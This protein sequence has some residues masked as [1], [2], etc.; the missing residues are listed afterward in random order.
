MAVEG[1]LSIFTVM[2]NEPNLRESPG[3]MT[4]WSIRFPFR[5]VPLV[6]WRSTIAISPLWW[7]IRQCFFEME[8]IGI[9][10]SQFGARPIKVGPGGKWKVFCQPSSLKRIRF[11]EFCFG[12]D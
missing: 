5:K 4:A 6:E 10:R 7:L 9:G 3:F 12:A 1:W 2:S 11:T 8:I